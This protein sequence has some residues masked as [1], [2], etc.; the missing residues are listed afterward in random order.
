MIEVTDD[1]VKLGD[2]V[3]PHNEFV[4]RSCTNR[5]TTTYGNSWGWIENAP[6]NVCWSNDPKEKLDSKQAQSLVSAHNKWLEDIQP[7]QLKIIKAKKAVKDLTQT[8]KEKE[9]ACLKAKEM[10]EKAKDGLAE[11][12]ERM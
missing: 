9:Q 11:L 7:I 2:I 12:L 5:H 10:L 3:V 4:W 1:Y 8:F 6:G